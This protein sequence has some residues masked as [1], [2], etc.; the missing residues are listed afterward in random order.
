MGSTG[1]EKSI[2]ATTGISYVALHT[3]KLRRSFTV[4][5][6]AV[7]WRLA[8]GIRDAFRFFKRFSPDVLVSK[9]GF[10]LKRSRRH[11]ASLNGRD[12]VD[13]CRSGPTKKRRLCEFQSLTLWRDVSVVFTSP[14]SA[15]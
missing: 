1:I 10:L 3:T 9:G 11:R 2:I 7:P 5:N 4:S 6:L 12:A 14:S 15:G 8:L 13:F